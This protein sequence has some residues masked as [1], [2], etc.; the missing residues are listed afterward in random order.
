M[1]VAINAMQEIRNSIYRIVLDDVI[2]DIDLD[3]KLCLE[4]FFISEPGAFT[5]HL[6]WHTLQYGLSGG[7]PIFVHMHVLRLDG[8]LGL[9]HVF[10]HRS[11]SS[12]SQTFPHG[13]PVSKILLI[14]I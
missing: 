11:S 9:W 10:L 13:L 12:S 3:N 7:H 8:Y 14:K 6:H 1:V 5:R 4:S 2:D